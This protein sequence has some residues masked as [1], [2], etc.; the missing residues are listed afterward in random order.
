MSTNV[1][2]NE[3]QY[4]APSTENTLDDASESGGIH[5]TGFGQ[6]TKIGSLPTVAEWKEWIAVGRD[7]QNAYS[8]IVM[9]QFS[10]GTGCEQFLHDDVDKLVNDAIAKCETRPAVILSVTFK[11]ND[12]N[13]NAA[14]MLSNLREVAAFDR[15]GLA[16][17]DVVQW[18]ADIGLGIGSVF[19]RSLSQKERRLLKK[20]Y[21]D[22]GTCESVAGVDSLS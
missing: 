5:I 11:K 4:T 9:T 12:T 8:T 22:L 7:C 17:L 3:N 13:E 16:S 18:R 6:R 2:V 14:R 21:A 19:S 1:D 15:N 20:H 10:G